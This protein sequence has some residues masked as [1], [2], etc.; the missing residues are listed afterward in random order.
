MNKIESVN[1]PKLLNF[2]T[3]TIVKICLIFL[4]S[5]IIASQLV[6]FSTICKF[7]KMAYLSDLVLP[8][9]VL[10]YSRIDY[11]GTFYIPLKTGPEAFSVQGYISGVGSGF[12]VN[13][14]GYI[15]TNGHV[16]FCFESK[17]FKEDPE[18]KN[19]IIQDAVS[20]LLNYLSTEYGV[21]FSQDEIQI[22]LNYNIKN[23]QIERSERSVF[24][25]LGEATGDVIE[26]KR[27]ISATVV[28]ADPFMGRDLAILKVELR[29]TPSLLIAD[30][31]EVKVGDQVYAFGYPGVATFHP[32]LSS[33]TLLVPSVT[34]GIVSAKKLTIK[35]IAAIQHSAPTTHG[36]SG[37][38]LV[39]EQGRVVGVNNMGSVSEVGLEVAGFNFAVASNVLRDFLRENGVENSV[40]DTTIQYQKGLA[41]YYAKMYASAKKQFEIVTTLFPYHWRAKQLEQECVAAIAKGEKANSS[42]TIWGGPSTVKVKKEAITINGSIQHTSEMPIDVEISWPATQVTLEYMKPDKSV[43]TH[44]VTI[45]KKGKF[46]DTLIPDVAG[47]WSVKASWQGDEDHTGATSNTFTFTVSEPSLVEILTETGLIYVIP[48]ALVAI[49]VAVLFIIRRGKAPPPPPP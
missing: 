35:D 9:V 28:N 48:V 27:G 37:G 43:V 40:G 24:V 34:Q 18:T 45:S 12:F 38:P 10:V 22:I 39:D 42:V 17:N 14:N 36:N 47:Q 16:V 23:G 49:I 33:N 30:S 44:T 8:S 7:S 29:N 46:T 31:D 13:P 15:V 19:W 1:S 6:P 26:A 11:S 3:K 2:K 20:R 32:M 21:Y 41:F 5:A 4:I 25:I